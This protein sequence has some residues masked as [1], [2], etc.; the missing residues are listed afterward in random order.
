MNYNETKLF[1]TNQP[2]ITEEVLSDLEKKKLLV[3]ESN[4]QFGLKRVARVRNKNVGNVVGYNLLCEGIKKGFVDQKTARILLVIE[5]ARTKGEPR[6]AILDRL[7]VLA[8]V[9]TKEEVAERIE[10]IKKLA[11]G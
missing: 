6:Q 2:E 3:T 7:M 9:Q 5:V 8:F 10:A 1:G 11:N 4:Y